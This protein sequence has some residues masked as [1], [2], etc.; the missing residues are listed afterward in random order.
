MKIRMDFVTNSSSSSFV[1]FSIKNPEL[2][3]VFR[4]CGMEY[5]VKGD[6]VKGQLSSES[7]GMGTPGRGSISAWMRE[8][9]E[10]SMCIKGEYNA[11]YSMIEQLSE[12]ID[13]ATVSA[14]IQAHTIVSDDWGS[15]YQSEERK[16]GKIITVSMS[17]GSWNSTKEGQG[18]WEALSGD[19]SKY[20]AELKKNKSMFSVHND[21]WYTPPASSKAINTQPEFFDSLP[22]DFSLDYMVCCLTGDFSFGTKLQV[23]EYIRS[24]GGALSS[25]VSKSIDVLIVGSKGNDKWSHGNYGTKIARAIELKASGQGVLILKEADVLK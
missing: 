18:L 6:V 20:R 22:D 16:N 17:E 15:C 23:E 2:A 10:M 25:S 8:C 12:R 24:L 4:R 3:N 19:F 21:P 14:D 11:L 7:T 9:L 13:D 1:V 5:L